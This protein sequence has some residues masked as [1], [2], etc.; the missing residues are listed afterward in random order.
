MHIPTEQTKCIAQILK[1]KVRKVSQRSQN[2][3][4][5]HCAGP[6]A[7]KG[8]KII[9]FPKY[10]SPRDLQRL[11]M[12]NLQ[13]YFTKL[14]FSSFLMTDFQE[15]GKSIS[16]HGQFSMLLA[17]TKMLSLS[18]QRMHMHRIAFTELVSASRIWVWSG[19]RSRI[20]HRNENW[21]KVWSFPSLKRKS[22]LGEIPSS[23]ELHLN[24]VMS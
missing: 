15:E 10:Q 22:L 7:V 8:N 3:I 21:P 23:A 9:G 12:L 24:D 13:M 19:Y 1:V 18:S 6:K 17:G 14:I 2:H 11:L 16:M 4:K 5:T 20:S